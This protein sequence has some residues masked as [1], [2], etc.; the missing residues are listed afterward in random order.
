MTT[1]APP[2]RHRRRVMDRTTTTEIR[3]CFDCPAQP[4]QAWRRGGQTTALHLVAVAA[5]ER[6]LWGQLAS[7][8]QEGS[9]P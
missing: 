4:W 6:E 7:A 3:F 9:M 5:T 2:V 8:R 1:T